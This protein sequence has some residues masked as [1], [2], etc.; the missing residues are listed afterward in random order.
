MD[1]SYLE[2][3]PTPFIPGTPFPE[4]KQLDADSV[5]SRIA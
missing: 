4:K 3:F 2:G 1:K 5:L